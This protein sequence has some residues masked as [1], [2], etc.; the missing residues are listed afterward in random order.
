MLIL[1]I[2]KMSLLKI[3][4]KKKESLPVITVK[5]EDLKPGMKTARAIINK[6]GGIL[7]PV[8]VILTQGQINKLKKL[9]IVEFE[10]LAE[11]EKYNG[12]PSGVKGGRKHLFLAGYWL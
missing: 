9:S 10:I 12:I 2:L 4:R 11:D 3:L 6:H 1:L 7:M 8:G 5:A